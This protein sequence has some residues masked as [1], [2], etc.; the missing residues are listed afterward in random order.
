MTEKEKG[1]YYMD[2]EEESSSSFNFQTIYTTLI[3]NWKWFVLSIIIC[4][5][6]ACLYLRYAT[7]VYSTAAKILIK[8]NNNGRS[9][10]S[11]IVDN[12][13]DF[14]IINSNYG[15]E[16]EQEILSTTTIGTE[17][18][19][20][21]KLYVSYKQEGRIKDVTLYKTQP[22]NV[23]MDIEK[24]DRLNAPINLTITRE[25]KNYVVKGTYYV[26]VDELTSSGP[27]TI[28]KTL[29]QLP[30][31]I[32]TKAG[33]IYLSKNGNKPFYEGKAL[34]V[35]IQSPLSASYRYVG[36]LGVEQTSKNTSILRLSLKDVNINRALDYLKQLAVVY[37]RQANEDKNEIAARTEAFVNDRLEKI[38]VELSSTEGELESYKRNNRLIELKI[39]AKESVANLSAYEQ[40][41]NEA[42]TQIELIN[43]LNRFASRPGNKYK[44]LPSNVGLQDAASDALINDYNKM[45]LE[46]S[47]LLRSASETS[48]VVIEM[49]SQLD[50]LY[51]SIHM[52][53]T[54]AR[55]NLEIQ[56]NAIAAQCG[57]YSTEVSRSP[58]Q[59]RILTQIGRQRE[60]KSGLYLMLLQKR[61][62]NSISLAATADK[63]KLIELPQYTGK[64]SPQNNMI[65]LIA[66]VLGIACPAII[67]LAIQLLRYRIEG[68]E[69]VAKL[70]SLP[71]IADVAI[72]SETAKTKADIVVHENENNQMEEI[73]RS[74][75]TNLQFMLK[76]GEKCVMFTSST[77]GE[78]KTF[79]AA[80]L[81]MSF[82][83]L[84][85]KVVLV[86]L[87]IRKPRLAE[88]FE[89][90]NKHQGITRLLTKENITLEDVNEQIIP[91]GVNKNFDLLMS[92][93]VPPNPTELM[94]R[95]SLVDVIEILKQ[96]YDYVLMDTAPVGLVTDTLQ[97]GKVAD[98]TLYMCRADYTPKNSFEFTN[99]LAKEKKL[100][101]MAIVINGIDMSKR[102]HSYYYGYGKYSKYGGYRSHSYYGSYNSYGN[103]RDSNYSNKSDD[104]IKL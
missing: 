45:A 52:A 71:I 62:E 96:Q 44:V 66:L 39:D 93:P 83:L 81:A 18:V 22:V 21:L 6:V 85:K 23:D 41:L 89:I 2:A 69:D 64:V 20:D 97:V 54:Q 7:P 104:S 38:N 48:P 32:Y 87:D 4:L 60:I 55:K 65:F 57:Q 59:E 50:D 58:A 90:K 63:G 49:T 74:M 61:E 19:R 8:D 75:R 67:L 24:A 10:K 35:T 80:N 25:G 77:S 102:K 42:N 5:G 37:N 36:S 17:V 82:A 14:G 56:R 70:T 33:N 72:A 86:G 28:D 34:L 3:L 53:L 46:R 30:A 68:H 95:Q 78:G 73:F 100:P 99:M 76:P 13:A 103:Y 9:S 11:N 92:G 29:T 16:N 84:D 43:S 1:I 101:N 94:S 51:N 40:R 31:T 47:R 12:M 98:A 79:T 91:S 88:I 27:Y 26:T 15:I